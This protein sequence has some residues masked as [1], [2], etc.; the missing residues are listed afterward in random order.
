MIAQDAVI[1]GLGLP[2]RVANVSAADG[3]RPA[4]VM[5]MALVALVILFEAYTVDPVIEL[6]SYVHRGIGSWSGLP[7]LVTPLEILITAALAAASV[8]AALTHR[9]IGRAAFSSSVVLFVV[10]LTAGFARGAFA[11]GDMYVGLWEVRYLLYVPAVYVV[12][13]VSLRRPEHV[14]AF[15]RVGL[16]AAGLFAIEGAY[17][18]IALVNSGALGSFP[19]LFYEHDDVIFLATFLIFASSAFVFR[20]PGRVRVLAVLAA[21]ALTYT[22]LA[23]GR[24]SG[25]IVLI[26]G[27]LVTSLVLFIVKRKAFFANALPM[28]VVAGLFLALTWNTAGTFG[29]PARAIRSL[30]EPDPRDAASNFYRLLETYDIT[31]TLRSDPLLGV[32]FGREFLMVAT[33]PDLSWWPFWRYETHNNVLWIWMKL[34]LAGYVVFWSLLGSAMARAAF[35]AKKLTDPGLRSAAVFCLVTLVGTIVYGYVDLAFVSGRTMVMLG[36]V[37][38]MISVLERL[39]RD[40]AP[41]AGRL[42]AGSGA[43]T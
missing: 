15:L 34:G 28:L 3:G 7:L 18:K 21:P 23:S 39:D 32:G 43:A 11:G 13:R 24:R 8:S 17:R 6:G 31:A 33:L 9:S 22:L 12:A 36:A 42:V 41:S 35:A 1:R 19:D 2:E 5:L 4:R 25:I 26:V 16:A 30:Y 10:M 20:M 27:M 29:Q 37:L 14:A 40:H 38:G